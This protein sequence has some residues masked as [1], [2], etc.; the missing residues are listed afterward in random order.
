MQRFLKNNLW[1]ILWGLLIILLTSL[2]GKVFPR[3]P[4]FMDLLQPDKLVHLFIFLVF[5]FLLIRGFRKEGT[6]RVI[7]RNAIAIALTLGIT[8]GG[9]TEVMQGTIVAM[10]TGSPY[11]FLANVTGCLLG[12][13]VFSL[14]KRK[15]T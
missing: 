11:D 15:L 12:W 14:F 5:V 7:V 13:A 9:I 6:P 8:V 1:G 4:R 2:P 3:L 10:R